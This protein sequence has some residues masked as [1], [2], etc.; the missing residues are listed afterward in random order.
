MSFF[1]D[2]AKQFQQ[3]AANLQD[4]L[5]IDGGGLDGAT[6][7]SLEDQR[8]ALQDQAEAMIAADLKGT[9]AQLTVDQT[10]LAQCTKSLSDAVKEVKRFDQIA[11]LLSAAVVLATAVAKADPGA[12]F[13]ALAGAEKA[14][15][16]VIPKPQP[17]KSQSAS[18]SGAMS[19]T[20]LAVAASDD[21]AEPESRG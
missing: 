20:L 19:G 12:V 10:R 8:D 18:A 16:A 11:G 17:A 14:V 1:S 13:S 2:Q 4:R 5:S 9:L 21:S 7:T 3:T 6:Y 15:A